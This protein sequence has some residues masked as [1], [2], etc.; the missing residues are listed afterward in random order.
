MS[1]GE[2][3]P[4]PPTLL[5]DLADR[6]ADAL[7]GPCGVPEGTALV[8]ACSGGADSVAMVSILGR[9]R[10]RWPLDA[11]VFV[12]HG[13]REVS[14]ER[15]AARA[16][17]QRVDVAF[18]EARVIVPRA[19]NRQA[20][21]RKARYDALQAAAP[22]GAL[23][24]TAHTLSDQAETVLQRL[25]RGSG[26]RGLASIRPRD[27]QRVRPLLA[28][29]REELRGLGEPFAEDPTNATDAYQRNRL[30]HLVMPALRADNPA[31]DHA[32]ARVA[33]QAQSELALL[34][35]LLDALGR[36]APD[37]RGADPDL[38]STWVRWRLSREYPDEGV[39]RS[40]ADDLVGRL[41][42]GAPDSPVSLSERLRGVAR[43]GHL[44][45]E[46]HDDPRKVL[47]APA[48]GTYRRSSWVVDV[49][50][51][52][53]P[54]PATPAGAPL[55]NPSDSLEF[56]AADLVWPLTVHLPARSG[57]ASWWVSD[58][59]GARLTPLARRPSASPAD[60]VPPLR[61]VMRREF[62][63]E[64]TERVP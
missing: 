37:L 23:V 34:D 27:D 52:P 57:R 38:A 6:V 12:D 16:A 22:A 5:G 3:D 56:D 63:P 40:A 58:G 43:A 4:L 60:E 35:A 14:A 33:S 15:E 25:L 24:A 53:A 36:S 45:L 17:A 49:A 55:S 32:L 62:V 64:M 51:H 44:H 54:Q 31:V 29:S 18:R 30:R 50:T 9:L 41:I 19:G 21:A 42:A 8:A 28:I 10:D 59:L 47:V 46:P 48:P 11:V 20:A 7:A 1:P 61:V 13:F 2:R 39:S 26:L